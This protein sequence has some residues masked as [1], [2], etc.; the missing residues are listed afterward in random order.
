M[1]ISSGKL[2]GYRLNANDGKA[3]R[4]KEFFFDDSSWTVRFLVAG[5]GTWLT[6]RQ[7]L[8]SPQLIKNLD[9][10]LKLIDISL[11]KSEIG[12]CPSLENDMPVSRQYGRSHEPPYEDPVFYGGPFR[13]G[14]SPYLPHDNDGETMGRQEHVWDPNLNSTKDVKGYKV[15][16]SDGE[17]G[18]VDDFIINV[19]TWVISYLVVITN[20]LWPGKKVLISPEMINRISWEELKIYANVT[21]NVI[22]EAQEY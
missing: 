18:H 16:A 3:G 21:G 2:H 6:G 9:H 20:N 5:I 7:V 22:M 19:K 11:T 4:V 17:A 8:I 12:N 13:W 14:Y 15:E 1:L 10:R